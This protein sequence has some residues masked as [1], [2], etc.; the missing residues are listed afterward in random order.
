MRFQLQRLLVDTELHPKS[1]LLHLQV[2]WSRG[3]S[4]SALSA[5]AAYLPLRR[6]D[7]ER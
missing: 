3:F 1:L 7:R 2:D 4:A 6:P 5:A